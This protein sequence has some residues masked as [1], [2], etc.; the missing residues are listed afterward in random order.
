[1]TRQELREAQLEDIQKVRSDVS[2]AV[3]KL[4]KQ[5]LA[6]SGATMVSSLAELVTAYTNLVE[7]EME[8]T[9]HVGSVT[10]G[11]SVPVQR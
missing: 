1:M 11:K 5:N 9:S 6:G 4:A 10:A 8:A 3:S 7:A 2:E